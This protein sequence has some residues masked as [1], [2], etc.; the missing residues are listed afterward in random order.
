MK[1]VI[2]NIRFMAFLA[3]LA[4]STQAFTPPSVKS[5]FRELVLVPQ[6]TPVTLRLHQNIKTN[7]VEIGHVVALEV[8]NP[9]VVG[10]IEVITQGS[11][12]QGEITAINRNE[13]C[14]DCSDDVHS[15]EITATKV[16]TVDGQFIWLYGKPLAQKGKKVNA[17][18][19]VP[20]GTHLSA[21]FQNTVRIRV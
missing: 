11:M 12:A 4:L 15:I 21:T 10:G 9:V 6:G 7:E 13:D 14:S 3:A 17:P 8:T 1:Q 20:Q 16:K 2:S 18:F 19:T 5:P